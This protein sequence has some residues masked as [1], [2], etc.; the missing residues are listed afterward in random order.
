MFTET[1]PWSGETASIL[2]EDVLEEAPSSV[3]QEDYRIWQ[4]ALTTS[5]LN[6]AVEPLFMRRAKRALPLA[7]KAVLETRCRCVEADQKAF[8]KATGELPEARKFKM[9]NVS[10]GRDGDLKSR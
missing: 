6:S 7:K 1:S 9:F 8:L 5:E 3:S 4:R 10:M 2:R